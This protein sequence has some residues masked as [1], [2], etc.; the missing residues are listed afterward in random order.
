[1]ATWGFYSVY[2]LTLICSPLGIQFIVEGGMGAPVRP[3]YYVGHG[4]SYLLLYDWKD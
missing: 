1:M 2:P 4:I 3:P